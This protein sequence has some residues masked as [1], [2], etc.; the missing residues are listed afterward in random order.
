MPDR[1]ASHRRPA[2]HASTARS[3][4]RAA[5]RATPR[6]AQRCALPLDPLLTLAVIGLAICSVVTLVPATR[7]RDP[8]QPHYYVDRQAIYLVVGGAADARCSRAS[9]TRACAS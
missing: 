4:R 9:T 5:R 6:A 7:E 3:G 2:G 1:S 8:G